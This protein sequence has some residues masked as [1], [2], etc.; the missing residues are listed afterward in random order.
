MPLCF[1]S[2]FFLQS[3]QAGGISSQIIFFTNHFFIELLQMVV[4][5]QGQQS[6]YPLPSHFLYIARGISGACFY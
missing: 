5:L 4:M 1:F 6:F 2:F 3:R